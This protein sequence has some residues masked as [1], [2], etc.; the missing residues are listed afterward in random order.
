MGPARPQT[1]DPPFRVCTPQNPP[2]GGRPGRDRNEP[3]RQ[4]GSLGPIIR[5]ETP[6]MS[7]ASARCGGEGHRSVPAQK[8][9]KQTQSQPTARALATPPT[10]PAGRNPLATS[11]KS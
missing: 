1:G 2:I 6:A 8:K 10:W 3:L 11:A 7:L 5:A 9:Q 4:A